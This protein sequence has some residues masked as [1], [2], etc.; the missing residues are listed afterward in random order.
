MRSFNPNIETLLHWLMP[1]VVLLAIILTAVRL[2][3]TPAFVNIEYRTPNF[4]PDPYGFTMEERLKWSQ[5]A[6]NYLLNDEDISFLGDLTFE[7]GSPLYNE[8]ELRH[9]VDVKD[10]T[11]IFL[12]IWRGLLLMLVLLTLWVWR[13][14]WQPAYMRMLHNGGRLTVILIAVLLVGIALSFNAVFTGFHR[15]FFEGD[16]W[17][18][19]FSDTLIR[20]FPIRF[21]RDAFIVIGVFALG[22]GGLLW[23]LFGK[24]LAK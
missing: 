12:W 1:V 19:L 11:Q 7:D 24:R 2:L 23:W 4:P 5:I 22:S 18:F 21:W 16:T 8:R 9:M 15:I 14:D 6:L 3:L 13:V 17:L 10:L 20:L